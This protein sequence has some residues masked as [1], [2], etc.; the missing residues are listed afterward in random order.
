MAAARSSSSP[1][2]RDHAAIAARRVSVA[3]AG[4]SLAAFLLGGCAGSAP[5]P[6]RA[7]E[8]NRAGAAALAA[9]DY[10]TA[11]ARD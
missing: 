6:P 1:P 10:E 11:E 9:G 3:V 5:L 8:L 4:A 7:V 2:R